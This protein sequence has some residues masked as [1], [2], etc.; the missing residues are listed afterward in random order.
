MGDG[1]T[2]AITKL[3]FGEGNSGQWKKVGLNLDGLTSTAI[4]SDVCQPNDGG[5]QVIAYPDGDNGIDNSFGKNLL[6]T[7][8]S[9]YPTWPQDVN[10]AIQEGDFNALLKLYCLP[11]KGDAPDFTTKLFGGTSLGAT[12]KFDG[13]DK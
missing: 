13:T 7:I 6:P 9:V 12:P 3:M 10:T 4:S 2:L 5:S 1:V 8:I 11:D